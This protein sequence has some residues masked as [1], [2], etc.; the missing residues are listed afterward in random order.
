MSKAARVRWRTILLL[1]PVFLA[2]F[3]P[4]LGQPPAPLP[5]V[6]GDLPRGIDV[7]TR[8][9]VHE[10]FANPTAENPVPQPCDKRPPAPLDEMPPAEKPEG[11][12]GWIGGYWHFDEEKKD[13]LWVS[14]C[15]RTIPPGRQW[16]AG[17]WRE[18]GDKWQW[19]PGFWA[20]ADKQEAAAGQ[21]GQPI[22]KAAQLTYVPEP[23][24]PPKVAP[25]APAPNAD[26]FYMPGQ[27]VWR[28][29][30][31]VWVA[32]YWARVQP[33]Y[34]WV[35][36]HYRWTPH[37]YV[38]IPGYWDY[39]LARRGLLYAPVVVDPVIVGPGYVYTPYYAVPDEVV[40]DAFW[41]RPA[42]CHYYFGD[43]YGP[44]YRRYGYE[45]C[46]VY[47]RDHYDAIVVYRG[48]EFRGDPRWHETQINI[49]LARDGGR[50]MRPP[51][52]LVE[53]N[54]LIRER[55][56]AVLDI[57][58]VAP[59]PRVA[60]AAGFRTVRLDER[61]RVQ[62]RA[63]FRAAERASI[64]HR[65]QVAAVHNQAIKAHDSAARNQAGAKTAT[66]PTRPAVSAAQHPPGVGPGG[67]HQPPGK[68][69]PPGHGQPPQHG[70]PPQHG[71]PPPN[72]QP[73]GGQQPPA[74]GQQPPG[75]G[76][77]PPGRGTGPGQQE[78]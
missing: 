49:Y 56:G 18:Q 75:G 36:G 25:A 74:G 62:A 71:T 67:A 17:Y 48:W 55:G 14:G 21:A 5:A 58:L 77:Q 70:A 60:A 6:D 61:A 8:G 4:L 7:Q 35:P 66:P 11:N 22:A 41:V 30:R 27:Y 44:A 39:V 38:Y 3:A 59:G 50:M 46:L 15:W 72:N 23:P 45:C 69:Q 34:V 9:A 29:D 65:A 53:Q 47:G 64:E 68:G 63:D 26:S 51:R 33:G 13:Y 10:A 2:P 37:G 31:Y 43:Y 24:A 32:G 76:Q 52:T 1:M 20:A 19:A 54:I 40:V 28:D 16:I 73:P 42:Y 78:P 57:K 12:V